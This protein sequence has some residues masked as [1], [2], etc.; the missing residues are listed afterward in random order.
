MYEHIHIKGEK[1]SQQSRADI[2]RQVK[3]NLSSQHRKGFIRQI[4]VNK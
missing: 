4:E 3:K 1:L 2:L